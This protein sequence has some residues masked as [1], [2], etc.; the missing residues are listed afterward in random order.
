[1]NPETVQVIRSDVAVGEA[2]CVILT[3]PGGSP[4]ILFY[5]AVSVDLLA[6]PNLRFIE[7][8]TVPARV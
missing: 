2:T 4:V 7:T 5:L 1:M 8:A 3:G 6:I